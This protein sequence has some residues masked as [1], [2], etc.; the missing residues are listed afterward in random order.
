[1]QSRENSLERLLAPLALDEFFRSY[2]EQRHCVVARPAPGYYA[3]LLTLRD[4]DALLHQYRQPDPGPSPGTTLGWPR[5]TITRANGT[6]WLRQTAPTNRYGLL[7]ISKVYQAY[8]EGCTLI[9]D[10]VHARWPSIGTFCQTLESEL[11]A[12]IEANVYVTPRGAQ[13]LLPHFDTHDVFVLQLAGSKTWRLYQDA[14]YVPLPQ[15]QRQIDREALS[16]PLDEFVLQ[17]GDV[18]Y[19]PRGYVHE[20]T[21]GA[22]SSSIHLTL[23]VLSFHWA[24][25]LREAVSLLSDQDVR[26]RRSLPAGLLTSDPSLTS[27]MDVELRKLLTTLAESVRTEELIEQLRKGFVQRRDPVPDGHFEALDRVDTIDVETTVRRHQGMP[28]AVEVTEKKVTI[29]FPG[30]VV[31]GSAF[32]EPAMRFVAAADTFQVRDLPGTGWVELTDAAKVKLAKRLVR[33]GLLAVC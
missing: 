27:A 26:L 9:F 5:L 14:A 29:R 6:D 31:S 23:A 19:M 8:D 24:D 4:V 10:S 15:N 32:L 22:E 33:A 7:D 18:F 11:H 30:N 3:H 21:T 25:L 16:E 2:W 13:G 17:E 28:C 20:A 12:G 1:M